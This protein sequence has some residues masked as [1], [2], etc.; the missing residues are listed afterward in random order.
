MVAARYRTEMKTGGSVLQSASRREFSSSVSP[1]LELRQDRP[2]EQLD[3]PLR[4]VVRHA[5]ELE[6]A[7]DHA[8]AELLHVGLDLAGDRVG[9][10]YERKPLLAREIEFEL[11]ERDVLGGADH[12]RPR[13]RRLTEEL[14][15]AAVVGEQALPE[16]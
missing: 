9:G 4:E 16:I 15:R 13:R 3:V 10:A 8:G 11:V 14:H 5:A 2:R 6:E 7:H 1:A 12:R